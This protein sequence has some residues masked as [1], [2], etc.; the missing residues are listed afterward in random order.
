MQF[1]DGARHLFLDGV[2]VVFDFH[3]ADVA[4]R[5]EDVSVRGDF[6]GGGGFSEAGEVGILIRRRG[7]TVYGRWP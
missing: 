7:K 1:G 2:A 3:G 4:A 6:I 5:R